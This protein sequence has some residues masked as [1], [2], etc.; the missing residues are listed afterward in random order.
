MMP[1]LLL[2]RDAVVAAY[3]DVFRVILPMADGYELDVGGIS[4]QISAHQREF[5]QWSSP[6]HA[7]EAAS[8]DEAMAAIKTSWNAT[9]EA[10][11]EMRRQQEWTA[12]KYALWDA[13]YKNQLGRGPIRCKCGEMFRSSIHEQTMA[14]I[15]HITGRR[16]GT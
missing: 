3:P 7:G 15:E 12:N 2:R 4:K 6:G 9:D 1:A 11:A 5:W 8:R 16:A 10:L 13:G 14:H